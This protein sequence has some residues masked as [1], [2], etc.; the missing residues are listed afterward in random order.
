MVSGNWIFFGISLS[1]YIWKLCKTAFHN[2]SQIIFHHVLSASLPTFW[3]IM[4][5]N[6]FSFLI[7]PK[8]MTC[9]DVI[10]HS[11]FRNF[12]VL[13][14]QTSRLTKMFGAQESRSWNTY[15][16]FPFGYKEEIRK[17]KGKSWRRYCEGVS[18]TPSGARIYKILSS[19]PW[20]DL[21][22]FSASRR[23]NYY[24]FDWKSLSVWNISGLKCETMFHLP[25][26]RSIFPR[27]V[28][29][30]HNTSHCGQLTWNPFC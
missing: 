2:S 22:S 15:R 1:N 27:W 24:K 28:K 30:T 7:F 20:Q 29:R 11:R 3:K 13:F 26:A 25:S 6:T 23:P 10:I 14:F 19:D 21:G 17:T 9:N 5:T 12:H 8:N 16:R 18:C 4:R